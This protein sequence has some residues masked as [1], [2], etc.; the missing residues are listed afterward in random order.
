MPLSD[1]S[2]SNGFTEG[3]DNGI[4]INSK[5]QGASVT[6]TP[7]AG[8]TNV[9]TV[10]I[11]LK[12][13]EGADLAQILNTE[14]WLTDSATGEGLT[15]TTASGAVAAAASGGTVLTALTAKKHLSV[16]T[17]SDGS[18]NLS[19][20]DSAKTAFRIAVKNPLTGEIY[21]SSAL[22]TADYGA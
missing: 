18:F 15:A 9:T 5:M 7:T 10:D 2:V 22:A 21:V 19:I 11:Q 20:T 3:A 12:D 16:L 17:K 6:F 1:Y 4:F 13:A 14:I 8:A